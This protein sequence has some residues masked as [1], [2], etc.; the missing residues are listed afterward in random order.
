MT[1]LQIFKNPGLIYSSF[2]FSSQDFDMIYTRTVN[3]MAN[4]CFT[5]CY[6]IT[7]LIWAYVWGHYPPEIPT[8]IFRFLAAATKFSF[9]F[10]TNLSWYR[11]QE[12]IT[13]G[14]IFTLFL[15]EMFVAE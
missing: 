3:P 1:N 8:D 9:Y 6:A 5:L 10:K 14:A 15:T 12:F 13:A 4:G 7:V 11:I 2:Q